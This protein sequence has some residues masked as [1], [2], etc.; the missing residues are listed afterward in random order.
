MQTAN[1]A[2]KS[3]VR[4]S[5]VRT[6]DEQREE[7]ARSRF[8]AMPLAGMI[9]WTGVGIA[10]LTLSEQGAVWAT[11]IGTGMIVYLGL[12]LSRFTGENLTDKMRPK[13]AFDGLFMLT[14]VMSLLVYLIAIQVQ[15]WRTHTTPR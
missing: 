9:A 8:L 13:N 11:Y 6:L 4:S 14:V 3:T 12:F 7:F 5:P 15:R 2:P 1:A 10:G